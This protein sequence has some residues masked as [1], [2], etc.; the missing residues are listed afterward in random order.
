MR[1]RRIQHREPSET[2]K[3]RVDRA[4]KFFIPGCRVA[5]K[6]IAPLSWSGL[7]NIPDG[8]G[9][10]LSN[11]VSLFDPWFTIISAGRSVHYLATAAAM[12]DPFMG[13]VLQTFGS[14]PKKKF[15]IDAGAIRQMKKWVELG[16]LVASY[17]E[18]ERSWDGE[19]L[20]LLPG[21]EALVRLLKVPVIPVRVLNAARVMPRWAERRRFG[22]VHVEFGEARSFAR[23]TPP[24]EIRAWLRESLTVPGDDPRHNKPVRGRQLAMGLENP[25]FR[26]PHCLAW[27]A[28]V[29][30]GDEIRCREC[31]ATWRVDTD[32]HL[33]GRFGGAHSM[34]IVEARQLIA[35]ANADS[36][37][38]DDHRFA[39]EG[40]IAE[41]EPMTL[42]DVT[43]DDSRNLGEGRMRLTAERLSVVD[44]SGGELLGLELDELVNANVEIRRRLTY[45]GR[46]NRVWEAVLPAES[47]LKWAELVEHWRQQRSA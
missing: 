21:V 11:H 16:N 33:I 12:Q 22:P 15:T 14:I 9:L 18:G 38:V 13:R 32:N 10:I 3:R 37:V 43:G 35:A 39:R 6:A 19:L 28:L 40:L 31:G 20:P 7:D 34:S 30:S 27:D 44:R 42:L 29:P 41:S 36:F 46:D 25:L 2:N 26:C 45:R 5:L 24:E 23:R 17:P 47:P 8:P 4:T 1:R